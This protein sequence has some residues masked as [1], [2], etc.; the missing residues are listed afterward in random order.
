[1]CARHARRVT[2]G[3][4]KSA[5]SHYCMLPY[6]GNHEVWLTGRHAFACWGHANGALKMDL[7]L[8]GDRRYSFAERNPAQ[9]EFA[10][11]VDVV[12]G[13]ACSVPGWQ[14]HL[15]R[16]RQ[17]WSLP[18]ARKN[19]SE[20]GCLARAEDRC[21]ATESHAGVSLAFVSGF[22]RTEGGGLRDPISYFDRGR[23]WVRRQS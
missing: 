12:G 9:L 16:G 4:G 6:G 18:T 1:M 15:V 20:E 21:F 2:G 10:C 5:H 23:G 13:G 7:S 8:Y 22:L 14:K 11:T 3:V 19:L 17:E